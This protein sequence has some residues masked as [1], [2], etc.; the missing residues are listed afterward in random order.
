MTGNIQKYRDVAAISTGKIA[1]STEPVSRTIFC[2]AR[3]VM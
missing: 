2:E 1:M 3:A